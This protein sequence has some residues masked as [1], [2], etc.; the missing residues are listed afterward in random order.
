MGKF[1]QTLDYINRVQNAPTDRQVCAE[2]LSISAEF[3]LTS[4][5]AC[6]MPDRCLSPGQQRKLILLQGWP[7]EW[8]QIYVSSG[9]LRHDPVVSMMRRKPQT[10]RW[11]DAYESGHMEGD[12][13]EMIG[14]AH[15]FGLSDG[16]AFP[17]YTLDGTRILVSL[18]GPALHISNE[19]LQQL[20]LLSNYALGRALQLNFNQ[21]LDCH[22]CNLTSREIECLR[23]A[24]LGKSEWEISR[25]LG[26]SEHTSEKHLLNAK[27]KLGAANRT[28]AVVE[29][30]RL[31]YVS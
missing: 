13:R 29:A 8:L 23:W 11:K 10:F 27:L 5:I 12:S 22:K 4:L 31:G 24:A 2:L 1:E 9:Y 26:I 20:S 7:E 3:G 6:T 25:I 30:I 19:N 14:R 17:M 21:A 28:Q 18:G 16:I 15:E